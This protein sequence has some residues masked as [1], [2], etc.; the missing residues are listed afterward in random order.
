MAR[1]VGGSF[2]ACSLPFS[3]TVWV[4]TVAS[5]VSWVAISLEESA[6]SYEC[7]E[8]VGLASAVLPPQKATHQQEY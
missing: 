2:F 8:A 1:S 5:D 6:C 3:S 4:C 7:D